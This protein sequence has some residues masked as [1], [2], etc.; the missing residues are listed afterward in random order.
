MG[1][2]NSGEKLLQE[3]TS[4]FPSGLCSAGQLNSYPQTIFH[5]AR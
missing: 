4:F 1:I 2:C 5:G 3:A